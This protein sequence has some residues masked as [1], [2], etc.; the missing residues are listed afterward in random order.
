MKTTFID[1][2][3][4][5]LFILVVFGY[6]WLPT[7]IQITMAWPWVWVIAGALGY[8]WWLLSSDD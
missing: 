3:N 1:K 5:V 2:L 8:F 7:I 4:L 6:A